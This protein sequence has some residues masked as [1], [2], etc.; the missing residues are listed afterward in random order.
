MTSFRRKQIRG[1]ALLA[2]SGFLGLGDAPRLRAGLPAGAVGYGIGWGRNRSC[3]WCIPSNVLTNVVAL[4]GGINFSLGLRPD[5]TVAAWGKN[6][7]GQA[8]VPAGIS[9]IAA[10]A[11]GGRHCLVLKNDGTVAAWGDGSAGQTNIPPGLRG[12]KAIAAGESHNA[13][14]LSD[15]CIRCWGSPSNPPALACGYSA[16]AAG[17]GYSLAITTGG[18]I[19]QWTGLGYGVPGQYGGALIPAQATNGLWYMVAVAAGPSHALAIKAPEGSVIGWG[20]NTWGQLNVPSGLSQVIA[21]AAG[22]SFSVAIKA[23]RT[24]VC[25]GWPGDAGDNILVPPMGLSNVFGL[26]CGKYHSLVTYG[27]P[28]A[29]ETQPLDQII[30]LGNPV[31]FSVTVSG[32]PTLFCQWQKN[33]TPISGATNL[34]YTIPSVQ[35]ADQASYGVSVG[36]FV[37]NAISSNALLLVKA[38]PVITN[39]PQSVTLCAGLT[40]FFGVDASGSLPLTYRWNRNNTPLPNATNSFYQI[41][42]TQAGDAGNYT[43]VVS[44]VWGALTSSVASL[45]VNLPPAILGQPQSQIVNA[46]S[47]VTFSVTASNALTYQWRKGGADIQGATN[48]VYRI[49]NVQPGDAGLYSVRVTNANTCGTTT[50]SSASLQVLAPSCN[51]PTN[52]VGWGL[53]TVWAVNQY[54]DLTPPCG[55]SNIVALAMGTNHSLALKTDGTVTGWGD[56]TFGQSS[57]PAN[58]PA[59]T[60]IAA[61]GNVSLALKGDSGVLAWGQNDLGQTDVPAG[62]TNVIALAAGATHALALLRNGTVTG[63]GNPA[64]GRTTPLVNSGFRAIAAGVDH[65]LGLHTNG[66][67]A[68][69]G[70]SS[71]GQA[72]PP[73]SLTNA[74]TARV[75]AIAAGGYHSLA[76]QSNGAVVA[77][78]NND[79]GQ[80]DV[81]ADLPKVAALAAGDTYS[82]V[83]L[84]D[85][86]LAGWGQ[87][88][89]GQ[90]TNTSLYHGL[91]GIAAAGNRG[92]AIQRG[93]L[94]LRALRPTGPP[95]NRTNTMFISNA[96]GAPIADYRRPRIS[97]L[98][99]TNAP[100]TWQPF[101]G[102]VGPWTNGLLRIDDAIGADRH[103]RFYQTGERP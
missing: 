94:R 22:D 20:D 102:S 89:D 4:S 81:P 58:L 90:V 38:P 19:V 87:D 13:V 57:V 76:V 2:L 47:S 26:A 69:W 73:M 83:L 16:I 95:N 66:T 88:F 100:T 45:T 34:S 65:S 37:G 52:V 54:V 10:I 78:G 61:G 32:N 96:D 43:V 99:S 82:L 91:V 85:G 53:Q 68:G 67:V 40:A 55:L 18:R 101:P 12:V 11:A 21:V 86:S 103:P 97:V 31:T 62:L 39:Q 25:W 92:L 33:G 46:G 42:S 56:N 6:D 48:P 35:V 24:V 15:G 77:W 59:I 93:Q 50:S 5:G 27:Y 1:L 28:P 75:M 74:A 60:V 17:S 80:T 79:F 44:N 98:Y 14:L 41:L 29:I 84:Q 63:W 70:G 7:V 64:S 49:G 36:N 9:K 23:D 3:E 72:R 30:P 8:N 71:Y 51:G